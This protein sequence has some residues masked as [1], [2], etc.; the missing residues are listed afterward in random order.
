MSGP[1]TLDVST[2]TFPYHEPFRISGHLFTETEVVLVSLSD[3]ENTGRGEA[4]GAYYLGDDTKKMLAEIES[5]RAEIEAGA[6]REELQQLL[7]HGGA[8]NALD[9]AWWEL[10]AKASGTPVWQ[11]AGLSAAPKPLLTTITLGAQDPEVMAQ[12]AAALT[13]FKALKLKLTGDADVD[14][15][16]VAAVRTARPECWIGVDAN[17][18][19]EINGLAALVDVL[20][21]NDVKLLEQPLARGRESDLDGF[22]RRMP[23]AADESALSLE[24]VDIMVGR[25]DVLNIKLDKCGGLTEG[26]AIARRA[27]EWGLGVMVGNMMGSSLSMAPS[28][29]VGQLCDVVD[30]DGPTFLREDRSPAV[31]YSDGNIWCPPGLWGLNG[32]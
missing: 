1:I 4:A 20:L 5:V 23:F 27:K 8:R 11:L 15:A 21:E 7:P 30:L 19:Y 25:F 12:K 9:C 26:L 2:E 31:E 24:D 17:Q 29:I 6:T 16:R 32:A 10:E 22:E 28:F 18:G 3:G 13:D 14:F